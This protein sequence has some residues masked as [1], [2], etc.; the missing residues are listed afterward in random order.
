MDARPGVERPVAAIGKVDERDMTRVQAA[1]RRAKPSPE[2]SEMTGRDASRTVVEYTI[3][4]I[5]H[6]I[7]EGNYAPGQRL[8]EGELTETLGISRGPLR[9][10]LRRLA[11]DGLVE[12]EPYRGA[13]VSRLTRAELANTLMV[14]EM[15]EGLAARL[16]VERIAEGGNRPKALAAISALKRSAALQEPG[17][18]LEENNE[19]HNLIVDLSGNDVLGRQIAQLQ[20]PTLRA[21]F[22]RLFDA[23]LQTASL[24]QHGE[25]LDA[26]VDGDAGRAERVMRRHVRRTIDIAERLPNALFRA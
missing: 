26:I 19:F 4:S 6:G 15:L 2:K 23:T 10:A 16:A 21:A 25:I 5:R 17:T 3:G 14:R 20:L 24:A 9:E 12:L 18:Y 11:A 1:P 8:I 13:A 7:L 22:F